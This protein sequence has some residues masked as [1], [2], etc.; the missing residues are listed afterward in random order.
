MVM[1]RFDNVVE[2]CALRCRTIV[3]VVSQEAV[4]CC[5]CWDIFLEKVLA[6]LDRSGNVNSRC[7]AY[8]VPVEY[9]YQAQF[10]EYMKISAT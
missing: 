10:A 1:V 9:F 4:V 6:N 5:Y 3:P 2:I 7:P 8:I